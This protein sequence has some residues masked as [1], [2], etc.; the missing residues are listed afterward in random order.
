M[1][2]TALLTMADHADL[3]VRIGHGAAYGDAI[4]QVLVVPTE[5]EEVARE[6]PIFFRRDADG[7]FQSVALLGF[8]RDE[9]L[10]LDDAGWQARYI[11][12]VQRRGPF[13]IGMQDGQPMIHVDLNHPAIG[14]E[15]AALFLPH[16]GHAP[17]LEAAAEVLRTLHEGVEIAPAMFAAFGHYDLI[18]P[19]VA[20]IAIDEERQYRLPDLFTIDATALAALDGDALAQLNAAG[21][22][23]AAFTV[24]S[25]LGNVTDLIARK[26]RRGG[27]DAA[28]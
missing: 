5:Y 15:G 17:C 6:Y 18:E 16:G 8:E 20:E 14:P 23:R 4:N 24:L 2:Q 7:A 21:A 25:S 12:A 19:V 10:F 13:L 11:P 22:L 27:A 26:R 28:V 9:N 3:R 1:A